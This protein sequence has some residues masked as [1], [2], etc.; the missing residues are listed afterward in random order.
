MVHE[1]LPQLRWQLLIDLAV[2]ST[3]YIWREVKRSG[4]AQ[5]SCSEGGQC[6]R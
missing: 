5:W 3:A 4:H 1:Q 2:C 6:K